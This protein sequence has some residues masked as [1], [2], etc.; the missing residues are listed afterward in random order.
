MYP[1]IRMAG[2]LW[3]FR[4]APR[5]SVGETHV[6]HHICLPW[7]IDMWMELNNGRTLTLYDLGR[8]VLFVRLGITGAMRE[9]GWVGTVA[10][11]SVRYRA[12]VRMWDRIEMR[13]TI[14]GWDDRFTYAVQSMWR[15]ETCTSQALLR[16]AV[17]DRKGIVPSRDLAQVL[18]LP[19]E[20]PPLPDWVRAW[21]AAEGARPWPP[22]L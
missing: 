4:K 6:S 19:E 11:A 14:I 5:L 13:S 12:R 2:A 16:M 1:V 21:I 10:G 22:A 18:G 15:G 7:D 20:S 17:T 3:R 9:K 8:I